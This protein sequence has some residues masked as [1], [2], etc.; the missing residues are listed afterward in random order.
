MTA[1]FVLVARSSLCRTGARQTPA[2][3]QLPAGCRSVVVCRPM[4]RSRPRRWANPKA[5]KR[6]AARPRAASRALT[7]RVATCAKRTGR[8]ADLRAGRVCD[9]YAAKRHCNLSNTCD[10]DSCG[11]VG[12][13][14]EGATPLTCR[15]SSKDFCCAADPDGSTTV[16]CN[17]GCTVNGICPGG[18]G[19]P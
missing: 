4:A 15:G 13:V 5:Q 6:G 14:C 10:F 18:T 12:A 19:T 8:R 17:E 7:A 11:T 2:C 16:C 9:L 1:D 3:L